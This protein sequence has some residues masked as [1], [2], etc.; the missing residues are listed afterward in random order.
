MTFARPHDDRRQKARLVLYIYTSFRTC[1]F[2][3]AQGVNELTHNDFSDLMYNDLFFRHVTTKSMKPASSIVHPQRN[4]FGTIYL[5]GSLRGIVEDRVTIHVA[6]VKITSISS[7]DHCL[8]SDS[9]SCDT[10]SIVTWST[11]Q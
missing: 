5:L 6:N 11:L 4:S 3:M 9:S 8:H 7:S 1:F 2:S 10:L